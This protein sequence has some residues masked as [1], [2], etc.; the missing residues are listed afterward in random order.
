MGAFDV[1]NLRRGFEQLLEKKEYKE[2]IERDIHDFLVNRN[3]LERDH[4][5]IEAIRKLGELI[6]SVNYF[7]RKNAETFRRDFNRQVRPAGS[8]F[9][10]TE[11]GRRRLIDIVVRNATMRR[12]VAEGKIYRLLEELGS[13]SIKQ[14]TEEL[15]ILSKKGKKTILGPKGRDLYLRDMGYFDRIP[16]DI[17]EMRFILRTGIY[18]CCSTD[19][20]DLLKK[21]DLQEAL[22]NFCKEH[23]A[24]LEFHDVDLSKSPG[25]VDLII[26]YHS[27]DTKSGGF[28]VCA[29]KPKCIDEKSI[30]RFSEACLFTTLRGE[31]EA[32]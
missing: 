9:L 13:K 31:K 23:L 21:E 4:Y 14:W 5:Y 25:I 6:S 20:F 11:K 17:H 19:S 27:A 7:R 3:G 16:I 28:S 22:V 32:I 29:A 26:W 30:C 10:N 8:N 12:G 18:H 2:K 24:G 1:A 15:Y